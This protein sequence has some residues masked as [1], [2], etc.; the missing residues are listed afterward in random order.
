MADVNGTKERNRI[1][2]QIGSVLKSVEFCRNESAEAEKQYMREL[3]SDAGSFLSFC[4][5]LSGVK[6]KDGSKT[7]WEADDTYDAPVINPQKEINIQT[8][9]P[10]TNE[11]GELTLYAS[12]SCLDKYNDKHEYILK[13]ICRHPNHYDDT[14]ITEIK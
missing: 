13:M 14:S 8:K 9:S 11:T 5:E 4:E 1:M 3:F 2:E 10:A 7:L 6:I 12:M